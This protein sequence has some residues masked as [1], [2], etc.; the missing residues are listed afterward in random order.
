MH[1]P[2]STA[3][4]VPP[5]TSTT[6]AVVRTAVPYAVGGLL[7]LLAALGADLD[8]AAEALLTPAVAFVLGTLYYLGV[9]KLARRFPWVEHLLGV[10]RPPVHTEAATRQVYDP[11]TGHLVNAYVITNAPERP[12]T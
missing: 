3:P 2:I 4:A 11:D 7:A 9:R 10:A 6:P 12:T 5:S 1:D 8:P